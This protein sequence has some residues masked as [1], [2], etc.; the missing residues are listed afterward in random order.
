MGPLRL[1][2]GSKVFSYVARQ[3]ILDR[4]QN[5]YAYELLFR[6]GT[7]NRF[8]DIE[9]DEATSKILT[10]S[11]LNLGL[12]SI[13]GGKVSFINFYEETLLYRFPTSLDPLNVVIEIV[14]TT[15]ANDRLL[16]A[17]KH[18]QGLGY[19]LALDDYDFDPKWDK[20]LPHVD[21]VKVDIKQCSFDEIEQGIKKF[22]SSR[23]KLIA[24]KVETQEEYKRFKDLGFDYFQGFF[25]ARP[26]VIKSKS[27][28][29][30]S[31]SAVQLLAETSRL[32]L[33]M[34]KVA[35]IL[36]KDVVLSY[37]LLRF[38]NNP[39]INKR[40]QISSISHA[41]NFMGQIELKK[42]IALLALAKMNDSKPEELVLIALVRAK[43]CEFV[44]SSR[45]DK[46]NPPMGFLVGLLSVL[47]AMLDQK[48]PVLVENIPIAQVLKDALCGEKNKYFVYLSLAKGFEH[49]NW[50]LISTLTERLGL[51]PDD[52]SQFHR[53]ALM[54][55]N[56]L[57]ASLS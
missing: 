48:M 54:W 13:T 45:G 18:I 43:F 55:A 37:K 33:D 9:P 6:D 51:L 40:T 25:F 29:N 49:A 34:D 31:T 52:V 22:E 57:R 8:P 42:F 19:S 2:K 15:S 23:V 30:Y 47:D 53:D 3:A 10:D 4:D 28:S 11:H 1:K 14:E 32:E 36:E 39:T 16:T 24:E 20:F 35:N 12:E 17:C 21:I 26:E 46:E 5:V 50:E 56:E 41:L 27:I 38:I 44:S 7:C